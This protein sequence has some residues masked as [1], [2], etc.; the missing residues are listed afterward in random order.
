MG[1]FTLTELLIE[2]DFAQAHSLALVDGLEHDQV[3]WRPNDN[4]SA[5]A[6]HLGHQGAVN[7]YM[8]RNLTSAEVTFNAAFDQVFDSATPEPA[9]GDLPPVDDIVGYRE[10]IAQ[11]TRTIIGRIDAG[12]VGAPAQLALI[13][14]GLLRAVINHEYQHAR[15]IGEVRS[16]MTDDPAPT[17]ASQRLVEVDGYRMLDSS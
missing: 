2:Y 12:D 4:S 17:P 1:G 14:Q 10:A 7:H 3:A 15:W 11:S 8:V 5:M 13:A 6:W 16:T 9:R